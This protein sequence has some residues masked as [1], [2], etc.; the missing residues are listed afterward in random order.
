MDLYDSNIMR[1]MRTALCTL[2]AILT[3]S[4][5]VVGN[6][7]TAAQR[8]RAG[9]AV[10]GALLS[11]GIMGATAFSLPPERTSLTDRLWLVLPVAG[12]AATTG[13]LAGWWVA[14][15]A[16]DLRPSLSLSPLVGAGLGML[17]AAFVGGISFAVAL[18]VAIPAIDAPSDYWGR[19]F[20]YLQ[21]VEM[22]F[23]AGAFWG[24]IAGIP[25]GAVAVSIISIYMHF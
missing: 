12:V 2:L 23:L 10:A 4:L 17:G 5:S 7:F 1:T 16:L 20:T 11:T 24:G 8:V 25:A 22:G 21:S 6:T 14:D 19:D 3:I 18:A 9:T 15:A 13:A